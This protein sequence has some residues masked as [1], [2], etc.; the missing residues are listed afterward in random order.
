MSPVTRDRAGNP[1]ETGQSKEELA[2]GAGL[3]PG[4][5]A[6]GWGVPDSTGGGTSGVTAVSGSPFRLSPTTQNLVP[7]YLVHLVGFT[8]R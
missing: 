5:H 1:E 8:G 2:A 4:G 7:Q 3:P 6:Q